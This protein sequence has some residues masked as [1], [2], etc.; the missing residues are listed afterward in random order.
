MRSS[1]LQRVQNFVQ[2]WK[3]SHANERANYQ[4]IIKAENPCAFSQGMK[5]T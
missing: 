5:A 4:D 1:D 2:T 3:G